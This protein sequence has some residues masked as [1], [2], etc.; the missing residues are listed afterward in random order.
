[1]SWNGFLFDTC[2]RSTLPNPFDHLLWID[3]VW[4]NVCQGKLRNSK[5]EFNRNSTNRT[6]YHCSPTVSVQPSADSSTPLRRIPKPPSNS[7]TRNCLEH[8]CVFIVTV[9][10][11]TLTVSLVSRVLAEM[12]HVAVCWVRSHEIFLGKYIATWLSCMHARWINRCGQPWWTR[13]GG[14]PNVLPPSKSFPEQKKR[15]YLLR[16]VSSCFCWTP[17]SN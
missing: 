6:A 1:M 3:V 12:L 7:Q 9:L 11:H 16:A 8:V 4:W 15:N 2:A 10:T 5:R 17:T 14:T 13:C